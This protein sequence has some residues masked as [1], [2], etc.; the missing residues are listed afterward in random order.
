MALLQ[1]RVVTLFSSFVWHVSVSLT[2]AQADV[3]VGLE[4][5]LLS[6]AELQL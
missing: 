1:P 4:A 2:Q 5:Q 3:F 6:S